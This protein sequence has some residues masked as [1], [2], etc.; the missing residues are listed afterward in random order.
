MTKYDR[1]EYLEQG[2]GMRLSHAKGI[3]Q[4]VFLYHAWKEARDYNNRPRN[5]VLG[6]LKRLWARASAW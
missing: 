3:D 5:K 2:Y 6:L 1:G 4:R